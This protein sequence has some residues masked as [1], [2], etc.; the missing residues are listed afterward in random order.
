MPLSERFYLQDA[1][2]T[3]F[4]EGGT[5]LIEALAAAIRSPKFPLFLGRR[6]C[7]PTHPLYVEVRESPLA[8]AVADVPWQAARF[9]Q[10]RYRSD[11]KVELRVVADVGTFTAEQ[12]DSVC[13]IADLPVSFDSERRQYMTREIEEVRV[14]LPNPSYRGNLSESARGGSGT[15]PDTGSGIAMAPGEHDPMGVI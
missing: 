6:S 2:F 15:D 10:A 11:E 1:V 5:A 8:Q 4:V 3:G 9:Y 13:S 7:P 14:K 12:V